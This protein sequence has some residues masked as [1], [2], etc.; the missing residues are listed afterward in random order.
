MLG[1]MPASRCAAATPW[2]RPDGDRRPHALNAVDGG[3]ASDRRQLPGDARCRGDP[4][5]QCWTGP[6]P[7]PPARRSPTTATGDRSDQ[8]AASPP[9]APRT[10][11]SGCCGLTVEL[12]ASGGLDARHPAR[13]RL[14]GRR[15][16]RALRC[17][18]SLPAAAPSA[19]TCAE[20][21]RWFRIEGVSSPST[22]ERPLAWR[23]SRGVSW[24]T[25]LAKNRRRRLVDGRLLNGGVA[26]DNRPVP[27]ATQ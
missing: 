6:R 21:P 10:A 18:L 14:D 25:N 27:T 15:H 5:P 4:P 23:M 1:W 26:R 9:P 19:D 2:L 13:Q 20:E 17:P 7:P 12:T 8:T 24:E 11:S 16:G 22:G 3:R